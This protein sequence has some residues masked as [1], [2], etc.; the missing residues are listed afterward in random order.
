[1]R[2]PMFP[3]L[4]GTLTSNPGALEGFTGAKL[5]AWRRSVRV[6]QRH[7]AEL[8]GL[9]RSTIA[10]YELGAEPVPRLLVLGIATAECLIRREHALEWDRLRHRVK[11]RRRRQREREAR[12]LA[13]VA[14]GYW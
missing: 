7:L 2:R 12:E 4:A 10:R 5:A 11:M 3:D 13:Q 1:M 9:S 14:S 6:S 8:V